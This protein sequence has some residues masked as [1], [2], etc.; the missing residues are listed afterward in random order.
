MFV[1]SK[2]IFTRSEPNLN[3][4]DF[5]RFISMEETMNLEKLCGELLE[6]KEAER[7]AKDNRLELERQILEKSSL[8]LE[9]SASQIVGPFKL[10]TTGKL[11]RTLNHEAY[12]SLG[13]PENLSFVDYK[14]SINLKRLRAIEMVD[15]ALAATCIT[16]KPGKT[17]VKVEVI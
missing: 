14:P 2:T 12:L 6:A 1:S 17:S 8:K 4:S 11:T 13:L 9:G 10:T 3:R 16:M 15:P 5:N 7:I